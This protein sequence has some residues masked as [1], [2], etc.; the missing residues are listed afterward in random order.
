M[1]GL[2]RI[3]ETN[4]TNAFITDNSWHWLSKEQVNDVFLLRITLHIMF[5]TRRESMPSVS[6]SWSHIF[7]IAESASSSKTRRTPRP[8]VWAAS[9]GNMHWSCFSS[10]RVHTATRA[11]FQLLDS[12]RVHFKQIWE[13]EYWHIFIV[14]WGIF[15]EYNQFSKS[16]ALI[17]GAAVFLLIR[18]LAV[19]GS[20]VQG[21]QLW[22]GYLA[23]SAMVSPVL[24]LANRFRSCN[25]RAHSLTR[26][27]RPN[28]EPWLNYYASLALSPQKKHCCVS[29]ELV[30]KLQCMTSVLLMC[31]SI[32]TF[33]RLCLSLY[34]SFEFGFVILQ[35]TALMSCG[36]ISFQGFFKALT[37]RQPGNNTWLQA[38]YLLEGHQF[39]CKSL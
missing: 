19:S 17:N 14:C 15:D 8:F 23:S 33:R 2:Y 3:I 27:S 9:P 29:S 35:S 28:V 31:G 6:A 38:I 25:C 39:V 4:P 1:L 7:L 18:S 13:F 30:T 12:R 10:R 37:F 5:A 11:Y 36:L 24:T 21:H 16:Y 22:I 26:T 34:N 20:V 32:S